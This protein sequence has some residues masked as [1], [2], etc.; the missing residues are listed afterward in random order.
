[1]SIS[2][3]AAD[4]T[5]LT[6]ASPGRPTTRFTEGWN[7]AYPWLARNAARPLNPLSKNVSY[8][9]NTVGYVFPFS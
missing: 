3:F 8:S 2:R 4:V 7:T 6:H 1:M 5:P 9:S